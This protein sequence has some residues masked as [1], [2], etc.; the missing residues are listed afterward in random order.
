MSLFEIRLPRRLSKALRLPQ[1]NVDRQQVKVLKK[2]LRKAQFTEFGQQ[3]KFDEILMS[4]Y[5]ARKFQE[6]VPVYDYNSIYRQW[7]HKT[8]DEKPDVCW[9]GRIKYY[10][11]SSGTS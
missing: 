3:F 6:L 9:P 7:W 2:L 1:N 4:K 8:L 11:L 10:A 5:P